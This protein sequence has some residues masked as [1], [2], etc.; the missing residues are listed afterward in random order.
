M[1]ESNADKIREQVRNAVDSIMELILT[2][3]LGTDEQ[4]NDNE[5]ETDKGDKTDT[6]DTKT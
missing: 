3:T 2:M 6:V 5:K 4:K 1:A